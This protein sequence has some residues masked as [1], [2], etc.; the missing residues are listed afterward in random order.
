MRDYH[1]L[2]ISMKDS[3]HIY[4]STVNSE[5]SAL[6]QNVLFS[7]PHLEFHFRISFEFSK[8]HSDGIG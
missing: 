2:L 8:F 3:K 4:A 5:V 6:S 1:N 7:T